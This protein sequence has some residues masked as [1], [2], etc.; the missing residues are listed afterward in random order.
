M[1]ERGRSEEAEEADLLAVFEGTRESVAWKAA[2]WDPAKSLPYQVFSSIHAPT[3]PTIKVAHH[4]QGCIPRE[5]P[6]LPEIMQNLSLH[7]LHLN[8]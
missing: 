8:M 5:V 6:S 2:S 1:Q 4:V 3:Q 7:A